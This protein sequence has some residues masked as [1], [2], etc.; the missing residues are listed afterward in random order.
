MLTVIDIEG[1]YLHTPKNTINLEGVQVAADN[2]RASDTLV[3]VLYKEATLTFA[4]SY[5]KA[6]M[7]QSMV[8]SLSKEFILG[9]SVVQFWGNSAKVYAVAL[10]N[11]RHQT[12]LI[13]L[14]PSDSMTHSAAIKML[15]QWGSNDY[16]T[17][18]IHIREQ[19]KA[20]EP[21]YT[22]LFCED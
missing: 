10:E 16:K 8:Y 15:L 13:L 2:S 17:F 12:R 6:E 3:T 1:L 7:P 4:E 5:L 14:D 22:V 9:V 11:V 21:G 20:L 19:F 18:S